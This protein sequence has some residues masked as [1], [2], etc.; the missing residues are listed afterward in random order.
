MGDRANVVVKNS[1]TK[2][3]WIYT[4]WGGYELAARVQKALAKK[5]RWDDESYLT[6]IIY[7][8]VVKGSEGEETGIGISTHM[9]DNQHKIIVVCAREQRVKFVTEGDDVY[10]DKGI[11]SWNFEEFVNLSVD[12]LE[13][14]YNGD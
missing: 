2:G 3:V 10:I 14:A 1:D 13:E 5:W 11:Y 4:H 8:E 7:D 12:D 9:C 6:R